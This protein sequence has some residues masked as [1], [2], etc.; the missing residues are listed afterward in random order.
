MGFL[1]IGIMCKDKQ[2]IYQLA[3]NLF[4]DRVPICQ[5]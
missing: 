2:Q 3:T 5:R 4:V 1:F